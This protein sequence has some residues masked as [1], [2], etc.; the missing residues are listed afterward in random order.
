MSAKPTAIHAPA[1]PFAETATQSLDT[2]PLNRI[3]QKHLHDGR[4]DFVALQKDAA[5]RADLQAFLA[6]IAA[7]PESEPLASWINTY[8]ALVIDAVLQRYPLASV[9]EVPDFFSKIMYR[10]AGVERSLDDDVPIVEQP[11]DWKL[12]AHTE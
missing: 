10:V 3:L 8:N 5:A 9:S 4:L 7:M 6:A 1:E 2:A 12:G 11:Y